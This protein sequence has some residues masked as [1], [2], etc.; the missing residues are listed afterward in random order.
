MSLDARITFPT[1]LPTD[2]SIKLSFPNQLTPVFCISVDSLSPLPLSQPKEETL[3]GDTSTW[4]P[5][6]ILLLPPF[7]ALLSKL[8]CP[9]LYLQ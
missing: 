2:Q 5:D 7:P 6:Q 9:G 4:S 1:S 3:L 8:S